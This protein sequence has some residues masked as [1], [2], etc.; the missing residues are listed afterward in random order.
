MTVFTGNANPQL[1]RQI[2]QHLGLPLGNAT[3][4]KFSDGEI[5]VEIRENVR[6]KDVFIIQ[7]TCFP[8]NDCLMELLLLSDALRRSSANRITAVMPYYGYS[9]QDRRPRSARVAIS[10]KVVAN[11]IARVGIDRVMTLDLHADQIQGFFDFPVDNIYS[12]PIVLNDILS[13]DI[14][15]PVIVSPDI[16]GVVRARAVAKRVGAKLAI[17]DKRRPRPNE[18]EVMN[19]IG[20]DVSECSCI[21]VDDIVDT[22]GTLSNAASALKE[23]GAKNVTAYC[24]HAV[25]SGN[26][27]ANIAN[28]GLDELVVA[29]SIPL[30]EEAKSCE[31]IRVLSIAGLVAE[32]IRR[33][34]VEESIS[35]LFVD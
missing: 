5:Q 9:R 6:G 21:L 2:V 4:S 28:S 15:S 1:A 32:S 18:S 19:I 25:L 33:I 29:D 24:T 17:I 14:K 16:G 34:H 8:T 31:K 10:A 20:D 23:R 35:S 26:A 22:A 3:V 13:K 7:P 11:M 12:T 30:R 27:L